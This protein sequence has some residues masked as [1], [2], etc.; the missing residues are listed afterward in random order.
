MTK[1]SINQTTYRNMGTG[2]EMGNYC[3]NH[4]LWLV[5]SKKKSHTHIHI[6]IHVHNFFYYLV[7]N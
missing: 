7:P 6:N 3:Y 2:N 1:L 4:I 5:V